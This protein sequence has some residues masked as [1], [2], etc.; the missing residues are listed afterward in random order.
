MATIVIF[1][2]SLLIAS[3]L[4]ITKAIELKYGR[5]N[6]FLEIINKLDSRSNKF[7]FDLRFRSLQFIQ[8]IRYILLVQTKIVMKNLLDKVE[9]RI[10]NEYKLKQSVIMGR[11]NIVDRGS[12]SFYLKKI[13]EDK[14]HSGRGKIEESL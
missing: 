12:V 9:E 7:I 10:M 2:S 6:F 8:I 4:L 5:K 13:T 1:A 3:T 14:G 11:R